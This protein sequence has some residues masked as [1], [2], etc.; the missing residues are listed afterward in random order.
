MRQYKSK[1]SHNYLNKI[2]I[3]RIY[4]IVFN[5]HATKISEIEKTDWFN[6]NFEKIMK[7]TR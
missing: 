2:E 6:V 4:G 3:C 5:N 7:E 1:H